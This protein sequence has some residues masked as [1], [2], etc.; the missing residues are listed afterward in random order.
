[1]ADFRSDNGGHQPP[2]V[3]PMTKDEVIDLTAEGWTL[4]WAS[5]EA[6]A[7]HVQWVSDRSVH[8][9]RCDDPLAKMDG[10][11]LLRDNIDAKR[12]EPLFCMECREREQM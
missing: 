11:P 9:A 10:S 8:C 2:Y 1:M 3:P 5:D 4:V 7:R 6:V 12:Q